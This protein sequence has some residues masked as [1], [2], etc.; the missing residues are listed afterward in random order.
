MLKPAI[1]IF[2]L[3]ATLALPFALRPKAEVAGKADETLVII[4]P[5]NEAIRRE[6]GP[7]FERWYRERTG[8]TISL[9]WRLIGGTT[10]IARFLEGE[11][12]AS[13]QNHWVNVLGKP[14]SNDVLNG[15]ANGGLPADAPVEAKEARAAFLAS[16]VSCGIDLFYGGGSYDFIRQAQAGRL[17]DSGILQKHPEWFTDEVIPQTF[18]GEVYW[19]KEGRWVGTVLSSFGIIAN[20][21]ALKRLGVTTPPHAWS[22]LADPRYVGQVALADPTKSGSIAKAFE[23]V[24][25]QQMQ[26]TVFERMSVA[27]YVT[28]DARKAAEAKAV[29]DGWLEGFQ[30]LQEIGAN[31][32]YFTDSA[33]KVPIDVAAGDCAVGMGIDFYGRQQQ[34]AVRRRGADDRL[35]YIAPEGGAVASVDPVGLLRGAPNRAAAEA[36]IEFSLTMEGQ[37]LWNLKPGVPGGPEYY[38]L[39]RLPVRKDFYAIEGIDALRSDPEEKPYAPQ[40]RLIYHPERTGK[41]F[42]E[43]TFVMRVMCLDTQPELKRAW[44]ALIDAGMPADALAVFNDL[45]AVDYAAANGRVRA[46]L[47][48]KNK[49][50]EIRLANELGN[51]FRA[52]YLRTIELAQ[53]SAAQTSK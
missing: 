38:A 15:F 30:L 37:K 13:F 53:R 3:L 34:E 45:S 27:R 49:V 35:T 51:R 17:V 28:E 50:D 32:R 29:A 44:R 22:D 4:T 8:K 9:D 21:D 19:D 11:Y 36:F 46:A 2:V 1:I 41:L 47:R 6:F 20:K 5:H 10:E 24:I 40:E 18:A 14:W 16:N 39:R 7:A 52:Q 23:N 31:A 26:K 42:R 48:S 25:Q 12:T 33:Q 43:I